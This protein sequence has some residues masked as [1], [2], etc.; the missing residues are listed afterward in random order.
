MA[1]SA[2]LKISS[3]GQNHKTHLLNQLPRDPLGGNPPGDELVA[4]VDVAFG[5]LLASHPLAEPDPPV[6]LLLGK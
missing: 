1:K 3:P 2:K 4:D 5:L 6:L